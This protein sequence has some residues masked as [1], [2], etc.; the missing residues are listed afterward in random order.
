MDLCMI[1]VGISAMHEMVSGYEVP[2]AC[3]IS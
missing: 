1:G 2:L 3:E